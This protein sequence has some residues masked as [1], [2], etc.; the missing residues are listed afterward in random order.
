M[1]IYYFTYITY[2]LIGIYIL[3]KNFTI[4]YEYQ[5]PTNDLYYYTILSILFSYGYWIPNRFEYMLF[6][7]EKVLL[8]TSLLLSN[9]ILIFYGVDSLF[10]PNH[11]CYMYFENLW[12]F[13]IFNLLIQLCFITYVFIITAYQYYL[14]F[15][16]EKDRE[17]IIN[18]NKINIV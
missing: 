15:S 4:I 12:I 13:G 10:L 11:R 18:E 8:S 17:K 3:L 2:L 14:L 1:Y 7:N 6:S 16:S 9:L 5:C